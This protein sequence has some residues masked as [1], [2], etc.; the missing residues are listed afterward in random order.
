MVLPS[1]VESSGNAPLNRR[2]LVAW[3]YVCALV[4]V[5]TTPWSGVQAWHR[6][7]VGTYERFSLFGGLGGRNLV[8][9]EDVGEGLDGGF[10][11]EL[12]DAEHDAD[13][14]RSL[15]DHLQVDASVGQGNETVSGGKAVDGITIYHRERS[16]SDL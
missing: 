11:V 5:K 15:I 12:L 7:G 1:T 4:M 8:G 16:Q 13:F 3:P 9:E 2:Y 14:R 10:A 6:H